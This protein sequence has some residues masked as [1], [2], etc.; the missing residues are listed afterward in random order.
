MSRLEKLPVP[1]VSVAIAHYLKS[2]K[3]KL[4][5]FETGVSP[6]ET[7]DQLQEH[8]SSEYA[9]LTSLQHYALTLSVHNSQ[10]DED[11]A[12]RRV[13]NV[14]IIFFILVALVL[15]I[16]PTFHL[17]EGVVRWVNS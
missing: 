12:W 13:G 16:G 8:L 6:W 17:I 10:I 2:E 7:Y 9:K 1:D 3:E 5:Q 4:A 14:L 11:R 15:F